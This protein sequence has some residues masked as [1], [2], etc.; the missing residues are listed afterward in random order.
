V[1]R[2]RAEWSRDLRRLNK[3]YEEV[4]T[5]MI[6]DGIDGGDDPAG[7]RRLGDGVRADR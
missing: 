5:K 6:Q 7:R 3:R 4:V 1:G 2:S